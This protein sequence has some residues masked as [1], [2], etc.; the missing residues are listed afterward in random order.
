LVAV[1]ALIAPVGL[2]MGVPFAR[3]I[4]ALGDADALVPWAWAA[5]GGASVVSA[6][7]AAMLALSFGFTP[8][9]VGA[10]ALYLVAAALNLPR[11]SAA[12]T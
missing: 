6:V 12:R 4:G 8:V 1:V 9:L 5:N 7:A 2:L 10:G 11:A 3:G